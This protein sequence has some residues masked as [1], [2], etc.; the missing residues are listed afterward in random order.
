[1]TWSNYSKTALSSS[2]IWIEPFWF[3]LT[4]INMAIIHLLTLYH[5][6]FFS[7]ITYFY[8]GGGWLLICQFGGGGGSQGR[9]WK[10]EHLL[11]FVFLHCW[12][13]AYEEPMARIAT[14]KQLS[15]IQIFIHSC[16]W[17]TEPTTSIETY[18]FRFCL[19][20]LPDKLVNP[21]PEKW[22]I[23]LWMNVFVLSLALFTW[24]DL[25]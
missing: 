2:L 16:S 13:F 20:K 19:Y 10:W 17:K 15:L 6:N 25:W 5:K 9:K 24:I 18:N 8:L 12:P 14:N 23:E 3:A 1:M 7:Y 11:T 4:Q 21:I 22:K